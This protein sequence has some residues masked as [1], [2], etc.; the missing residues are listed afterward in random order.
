MDPDRHK[1]IMIAWPL[2]FER[3]WEIFGIWIVWTFVWTSVT[4][5]F[6][7][8]H[9]EITTKSPPEKPTYWSYWYLATMTATNIGANDLVPSD[10]TGRLWLASYALVSIGFLYAIVAS[11]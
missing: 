1:Q 2:V 10:M 11:Y 6:L 3:F 5:W 9:Y 7:Q 8:D 4:Y